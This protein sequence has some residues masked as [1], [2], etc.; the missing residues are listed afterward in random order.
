[1][2]KILCNSHEIQSYIH[3]YFRLGRKNTNALRQA[4]KGI[5]RTI[6]ITGIMAK[7]INLVGISEFINTIILRITI[8]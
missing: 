5:D 4:R 3:H 8:S 6:Q 2:L 1:M 7:I